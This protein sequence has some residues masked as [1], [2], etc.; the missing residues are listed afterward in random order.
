M[1]LV[2]VVTFFAMPMMAFAAEDIIIAA[3]DRQ[4]STEGSWSDNSSLFGPTGQA[5]YWSVS[6][7]DASATYSAQEL[8]SG[9]YEVFFWK[10]VHTTKNDKALKLRITH[11]AGTTETVVD[12]SVGETGWE[13]IGKYTFSESEGECV[14][15]VRTGKT[16]EVISRTGGVMFRPIKLTGVSA[17]VSENMD[18]DDKYIFDLFNYIGI[19]EAFDFADDTKPVTRAEF[20]EA[21]MIALDAPDAADTEPFRDVPESHKFYNEIMSAKASGIVAGD[22]LG[23]FRPDDYVMLEEA[24]KIVIHSLEQLSMVENVSVERANNQGGYKIGYMLEFNRQGISKGLSES[25]YESSLTAASV[26]TIIMNLLNT[27]ITEMYTEDK[28]PILER[29]HDI[30]EASGKVNAVFGASVKTGVSADMGY[31]VVDD[32]RYYLGSLNIDKYIG[33]QADYFYVDEKGTD[34][35]I[36]MR[37]QSSAGRVE[38][39][40]DNILNVSFSSGTGNMEIEY[41]KDGTTTVKRDTVYADTAVYYNN[42]LISDRKAEDFKPADGTLVLVSNGNGSHYE[43]AFI[44]SYE[45]FVVKS[46]NTIDEIVYETFNNDSINLK[47]YDD[48]YEIVKDGRTISLDKVYEWDVLSVPSARSGTAVGSAAKI[49]LSRNKVSGIVEAK[50]KKSLFVNSEEYEL[51][52]GYKAIIEN[53]ASEAQKVDLEKEVTLYLDINGKIAAADE[54]EGLTSNYAYIH[55]TAAAAGLSGNVEIDAF[56]DTGVWSELELSDTVTYIAQGAKTKIKSEDIVNQDSFIGEIPLP[57]D[58]AP[59]EIEFNPGSSNAEFDI[60]S[61]NSSAYWDTNSSLKGP[62]GVKAPYAQ[63]GDT[64]F[65]Y[66]LGNEYLPAGEYVVWIYLV[67][68]S[69]NNDVLN[70]TVNDSTGAHQ[71]VISDYNTGSSRWHELGMHTFSGLSSESLVIHHTYAG[72]KINTRASDVKFIENINTDAI[73]GSIKREQFEGTGVAVDKVIEYK[74][75][76]Q[77][78]VKEIKVLDETSTNGNARY[79]NVAGN[80]FVTNSWVDFTIDSSTKI[81]ALPQDKDDKENYFVIPMSSFVHDEYYSVSAYDENDDRRAPVMIVNNFYNSSFG[82]QSNYDVTVVERKSRIIDTNGD[83]VSAIKGISLL[84]GEEVT[85]I[86]DNELLFSSLGFGDIVVAPANAAG[87]AYA[88]E[89][90]YDYTGEITYGSH[91]A[92]TARY[93]SVYGRLVDTANSGSTLFVSIDGTDTKETAKLIN[94]KSASVLICDKNRQTVTKGTLSDI[95]LYDHVAVHS[96]NFRGKLVVVYR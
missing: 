43:Y 64:D 82:N 67:I 1:P 44:N 93:S 88:V 53:N 20:L 22:G 19:T 38:I 60:R 84:S 26:K 47:A 32:T 3:G 96:N 50:N 13:S 8:A 75:N 95:S 34:T 12:C 71:Y 65:T 76:S 36:A 61:N 92:M 24:A 35:L 29:V 14:K 54:G 68:H 63:W 18:E 42:V 40:A 30:Y 74:T 49:R 56:L 80:V 11:S 81:F 94:L 73:V 89:V 41:Y 7:E 33:R 28:F 21:V 57:D 2:F 52:D 59:T 10:N 5:A 31:T 45:N 9:E 51:S 70:V 77:G 90:V 25:A 4:F 58:V 37:A 66:K 69:T 62:S 48:G 39:D 17:S 16:D 46:V 79:K 15:V 72:E 85:I 83:N 27:K 23:C 78:I 87:N 91:S 55:R 86:T 6:T